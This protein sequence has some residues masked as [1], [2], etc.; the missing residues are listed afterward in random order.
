VQRFRHWRIIKPKEPVMG[1][2][3]TQRRKGNGSYVNLRRRASGD[4]T[5]SE[6]QRAAAVQDADASQ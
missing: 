5:L 1:S 2:F 3:L 4:V 6:R